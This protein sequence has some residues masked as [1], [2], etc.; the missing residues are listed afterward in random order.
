V[1]TIV[2]TLKIKPG[3]EKEFEAIAGELAA[4]VRKNEPGNKLYALHRTEDPQKYVFVERYD[5]EAAIEAHRASDHYKTLGRRMG[6]C[7]EGRPE[8]LRL[9]EI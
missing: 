5:D 7:M 9:T 2:A 4:A 3:M 6:P 1:Q 8:I